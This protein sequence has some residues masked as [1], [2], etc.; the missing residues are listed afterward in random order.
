VGPRAAGPRGR[1]RVPFTLARAVEQRAARL[2]P[3]GVRVLSAAAVLGRSFPLTVLRRCAGPDEPALRA[4]LRAAVAEGLLVHDDDR[5]P[6]WYAFEHPLTEEALLS[7]LTPVERAELSVRAADAVDVLYP[8]LPGTWCHLAARLRRHAGELGAAAALYLE[9]AR[10]ALADSGP[11][12]AI[13]VLDEAHRMLGDAPDRPV[14]SGVH[15]EL[16]ET[17]LFALADDG[18]FDRAAQVVDRLR[19]ADTGAD[20]ARRVEL[21]V[22]LAWAAEVA[23]RWVEGMDQVAAARA[24]LPA[25]APER[26]TA[27]IDA[28]EAY[29]TVSGAEQGRIE[30]SERL[31]RRAIEGAEQ[32][33]DPALA[34]QA[35]Y[36]VGFAT[37][38]RS[39]T[40]SD[41]CFR[42][43]LRIATEGDLMIWRN[44]GLI[45]L[46][47]NAWLAEAVT[48]S[49]AFAH[50]EA[51]RTGCVSL[52]HNAGVML[53][54]DAALKSDFARATALL[55]GSLDE[56][57]RL[58]LHSVTRYALMLRAV[59]AAHQGRRS[60]M[61]DALAEFRAGGGDQSREA[62]LALGLGELFCAL[63]EEDREQAAALA[64]RID[65][66]APGSE[67]F[68]HFAGPHGLSVLL[69]VLDGGGREQFERVAGGQP[70][71]MR[72]NRQFVHLADAVLLGRE[73]RAADA[74]RAVR[75]AMS[76][77]A[78]F[79]T[80]RH[81]GLRLAADAAMA[82]GWGEP[83]RW[84]TEAEEFFHRGGVVAVAGACRSRLRTLGVSVRQ[85]RAGTDRIPEELRALGITSREY[86]VFR[87]LV[88]RPGNKALAARLHLSTR[89]VEKHVASLVA[90]TGVADR[91][92]LCD[93]TVDFLS[94]R[95]HAAEDVLRETPGEAPE[96]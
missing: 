15:Q 67:S 77:A 38:G 3:E 44:H 37:R 16:L 4:C 78:V 31:A 40:E 69:S 56:T 33:V 80:A 20:P 81:L 1:A 28:V 91:A 61:R 59:V 79:P 83:R 14:Q 96:R 35:W 8:G 24:L 29:L 52:A 89:T 90:K 49:L 74:Q 12:T 71:R 42:R 17:L 6:D 2:G 55:D 60:D 86:D 87:L 93:Y 30:E 57:R 41:R 64:A 54:L 10:R 26:D 63:L 46:G 62:P 51:L 76:S 94:A 75:A 36:A 65:A 18:Q 13:A 32:R 34:C 45:G 85:R 7:L 5:G 82:D 25:D 43:T 39:L 66:G 21:H 84:L 73:G 53:A 92:R 19:R 50:R 88:D 22:R 70:A 68:F 23:G 48:D 9:V 47:S 27:G 58:Q 95:R 11:G 72:W